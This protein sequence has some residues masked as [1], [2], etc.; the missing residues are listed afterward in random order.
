MRLQIRSLL[1]ATAAGAFLVGGLAPLASATVARSG[2]GSAAAAPCLHT[3]SSAARSTG[4]KTDEPTQDPN[5]PANGRIKTQPLMKPGSVTVPVAFHMLQ[6]TVKPAG[7]RSNAAWTR[8][9]NDQIK[10]LNDSYG[11]RTGGAKSPFKFTLASLEFVQNDAWYNVGPGKTERDMKHA[12]NVGDSET[13][14]VY[15]GNIGDGLLGWAYFPQSYNDGHGYL[16]GV[17]MLDESMPGGNTTNYSEGDTLTH[18]VGHWFALQHTFNGGCSAS[19]DFVEDTPKE[20]HPQ[21]GCPVGEDTCPAPGL[22]PVHNFMDYSVDSCMYQ[23]TQG[24]V[25][26]MNDAWID[27]RQVS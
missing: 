17:V 1:V 25:Q 13:L 20:A 12:L 6:P 10:V 5:S 11:G 7:F 24:Q 14:N 22:D 8:M 2:A 18:E 3:S 16:D 27:F 19:N 15:A 9:V 23:F 21:F 4:A 26:R